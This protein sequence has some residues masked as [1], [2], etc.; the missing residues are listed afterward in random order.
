MRKV[1]LITIVLTLASNFI[2]DDLKAK[3]WADQWEADFDEEIYVPIF[4]TDKVKGKWS[5]DYTNRRFAI[6]RDNGRKDRYCG[7]VYKFENT[8]CTQIV[9]DNKRYMWFP[10]KNFCCMCCTS[11]KGCG[12]VNPNWITQ[13]EY[14]GKKT[15]AGVDFYEFNAKG[16][17]DNIYDETI[18]TQTPLRI[19]QKPLSDVKFHSSTYKEEI[20]DTS[21]FD[22][23]NGVECEQSCGWSSICSLLK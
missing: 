11:E 16:V 8:P 20:S 21:V 12:I 9:K 23:P 13:A 19:Y 14:L 6:S 7:S 4:G 5:Y 1:I 2:C 10:K 17:Q 22:L 18:D 3:Q 15:D